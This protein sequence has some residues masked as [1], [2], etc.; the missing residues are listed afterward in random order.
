MIWPS[1][2]ESSLSTALRRSSK[3]P[4]NFAPASS[5]PRSND[6]IRFSRK[7]SG[8]SPLTIRWAIP[9]MMAVFPTPG[10]PIK[11]GLFFVLRCKTWIV[12]RISSSRPMTGSSLPSSARAV[13]STQ[14]FSSAWR[15][16]SA[17]GSI[18][19]SPLRSFSVTC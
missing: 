17:S 19:V 6:K 8:T 4:R 3:S 10:S 5:A 1:C 11:T 7:P 16:A 9:S 15:L 18:I 13:R 14:Y 12:R 2:F